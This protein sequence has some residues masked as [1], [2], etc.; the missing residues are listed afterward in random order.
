M[1][2][3]ESMKKIVTLLIII[4]CVFLITGCNN[5]DNKESK[6]PTTEIA[7]PLTELN[8]KEELEKTVGFEV[9][10]IEE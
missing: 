2:E 10:I 3:E 6:E 8:S 9:P 1:K 7:N 4:T 5:K